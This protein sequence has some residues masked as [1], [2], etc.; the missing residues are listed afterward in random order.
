MAAAARIML[1]FAAAVALCWSYRPMASVRVL[2]QPS[3][4]PHRHLT[5]YWRWRIPV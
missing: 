2:N 1:A 4:Q 5:R 3:D